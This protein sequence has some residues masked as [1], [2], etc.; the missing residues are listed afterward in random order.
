MP[1]TDEQLVEVA[2]R[3]GLIDA[4]TVTAIRL[5]ARRDRIGLID[6]VTSHGRFP[7]ATLYRALADLRGIPFI[8]LSATPPSPELHQRLPAAM[9]QFLRVLPVR[10]EGEAIRVATADP[11]DRATLEAVQR[12]LGRAINVSL[13]DPD[14]LNEAAGRLLTVLSHRP[15]SGVSLPAPAVTD[16]VVL[17]DRIFKEAFLRRAS[18]IH[19]EPQA[20]G[21]RVRM[22]VDGAL[23][24]FQ[25]LLPA[26]GTAV[27]SRVKVLGG[28]D[29]AEQRAPQ[30]GGFSYRLSRGADREIDIRVA[31]SPTRWGERATLRL[32][33]LET[34]ELTLEAIGMSPRDMARFRKAIK[35]PHGLILLT[36]PTGSGKT[37][38][39]YAALREINRPEVNILTVEDPI[40]YGISGISQIQVD[41]ERVTFASTLRALLRHDPDVLMVGEI[42]DAETSGVALKAAMTG[43]LVFSTLHTH[44]ACGAVTRLADLGCERYLIG[45]T[46]IGVIAQRLV[47]RLCPRCKR[48]RPATPKESALLGV[49]GTSV[50][51]DEP[52]GCAGCL[53]SGFRGRVGLFET[54]WID[55]RLGRLISGG[56]TEEDLAEAAVGELT[57]LFADGRA[58][59]LAGLTSFE[60]LLA[61]ALPDPERKV[62]RIAQKMVRPPEGA[63][64]VSV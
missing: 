11:D 13:A 48:P 36:G 57:T 28:L 46:L 21:L 58:K 19:L 12:I 26:E 60:E 15:G 55:R 47:R 52:V 44:S 16:P 41:G 25:T 64:D 50:E 53:G 39:L 42:R 54:L 63:V 34:S 6:A 2:L 30:D 51:I 9:L 8:D 4:E 29:I 17:L 14:A 56:G 49:E 33:G 31:T 32:L 27:V 20:A 3:Q 37:T 24:L 23:Q 18:D 45:S 22:R 38:T 10:E 61:A 40:E 1:I 35:Q 59:V 43:H 5:K 7:V 62:E